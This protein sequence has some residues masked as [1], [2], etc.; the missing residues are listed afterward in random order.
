MSAATAPP[1]GTGLVPDWFEFHATGWICH[2]PHGPDVWTEELGHPEAW[3]NSYA[4]AH[5]NE[6]H[7]GWKLPCTRCSTPQWNDQGS[8]RCFHC[9]T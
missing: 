9:R 8:L 5:L 3:V 1:R 6:H 4:L 2:H 7:P